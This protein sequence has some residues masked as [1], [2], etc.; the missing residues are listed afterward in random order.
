MAAPLV[1]FVALYAVMY[2]AFGVSSPF[3]PRFFESRGSLLKAV[4]VVKSRTSAH[5]L[6][7]REFRLTKDGIEVGQALTDFEG[8]MTGVATY[9]G[10]IPLLSDADAG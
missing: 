8:V 2:A 10:D 1:R 3:L 7:I 4:S 5:E 9:R 6:T